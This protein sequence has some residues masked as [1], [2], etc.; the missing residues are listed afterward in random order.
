MA[1][2]VCIVVLTAF[3]PLDSQHSLCTARNHWQLVVICNKGDND[4]PFLMLL[5]SLHMGEPTRIK[6][7]LKN[8]LKIAYEGKEMR[9]VANELKVI[10]LHVPKV[11][12]Q[13]GSTEC[14]F[15]VLYFIFRFILAA[16]ASFGTNDYPS[17]L[18]ADWF[19]REEYEK[20]REDLQ[21]KRIHIDAQSDSTSKKRSEINK[22]NKSKH[23]FFHCAGSKSFADIYHEEFLKIG[24][25][26]DRGDLFIRT[27]MKKAG[28]PV[29]EE[30]AAMI[31]KIRDIKL[32]QQ[33]STSSSIASVGDA[34]EQ[35]MGRDRTGRVRGIGTGPTPKSL[36]GSRSEQKSSQDNENLKQQIDALE[37]RM[38]EIESRGNNK[39]SASVCHAQRKKDSLAGRRVRILT[40]SGQVVASGILMSDDNDNVVVGK[41]L[42][43]EYYE[44]SILIAHDPTASLFIKDVDRKNMNNVVGSHIN[45]VQR[46]CKFIYIYLILMYMLLIVN[47]DVFL[48][49]IQNC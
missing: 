46:I 38:K 35:V 12:Q 16:P 37:E 45:I 29:N 31:D 13:K 42:G 41:K 47:S 11:P 1:A 39:S 44:V 21:G 19:S 7:E 30:S 27:R 40:F 18:T 48:V 34:Y 5:D 6:N 4:M 33:S 22:Q 36:W 49:S 15:M 14:G 2:Q 17:F 26:L 43:G 25:T 20:F 9:V 28:G 8:F 24:A 32:T 23:T 3:F 10:D